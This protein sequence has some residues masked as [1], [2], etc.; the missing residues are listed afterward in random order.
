MQR[1]ENPT[2][3]V[4]IIIQRTVK[5]KRQFLEI[6]KNG[7]DIF[8]QKQGGEAAENVRNPGRLH[9]LKRVKKRRSSMRA[10]PAQPK[11]MTPERPTVGRHQAYLV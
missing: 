1:G 3:Y 8:R 5:C 4:Y 11:W 7:V 6:A 10:V 9:T 2:V